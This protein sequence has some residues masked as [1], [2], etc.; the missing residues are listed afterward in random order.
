[1]NYPAPRGVRLNWVNGETG[2]KTIDALQVSARPLRIQS[3]RNR[4]TAAVRRQPAVA[5]ELGDL[6]QQVGYL[7]RRAQL[8]V[9]ADFSARQRGPVVRP[10]EY[11]VLAVIGRNPG[12]SQS[13]LC[14]ALGIKR[15]N[16][17]A[18]ID[19]LE[20]L[21]LARRDLS[22][23]DRRSNRLQL[24]VAGQRA[25]QTAVETQAKQEARITRLL[26]AAGRR[27]LLKQLA[28]LCTLKGQRSFT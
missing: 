27:A 8:A 2:D 28:K 20:S 1:M 21:G 26:G 4:R 19:H 11:S 10:G 14:A 6:G 15:A 18:V 13:Q 24:T 7:L 23:T 3:S 25:L 9:F 22:A 5:A 16:L 12:L 17:V